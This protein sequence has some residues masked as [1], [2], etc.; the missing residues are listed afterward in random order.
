[1]IALFCECIVGAVIV[2][3]CGQMIWLKRG[4]DE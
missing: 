4:G 3:G 1:M 2:V